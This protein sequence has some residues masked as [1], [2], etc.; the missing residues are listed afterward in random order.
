[1]DN[2]IIS[3]QTYKLPSLHDYGVNE[4]QS[5]EILE[6]WF[7]S[8]YHQVKIWSRIMALV[9][10]TP[11]KQCWEWVGALKNKYGHGSYRVGGKSISP[12]VL[13]HLVFGGALSLSQVVHHCCHNPYCVRPSHLIAIDRKENAKI[14]INSRM[15]SYRGRLSR[16]PINIPFEERLEKWKSEF[17]AFYVV[18]PISGCFIWKGKYIVT[19]KPPRPSY[20]IVTAENKREAVAARSAYIMFMLNGHSIPNNLQVL[21]K[22]PTGENMHCVN[23]GHLALGTA[24]ENTSDLRKSGKFIN[25]YA[26]PN[27]ILTKDDVHRI[28]DLLDE[29]KT[30]RQIAEIIGVSVGAIE[31]IREGDNHLDITLPRLNKWIKGHRRGSRAINAKLSNEQILQMRKYAHD[32]PSASYEEIAKLYQVH[33]VYVSQVCLGKKRPDSK[34]SYGIIRRKRRLSKEEISSIILMHLKQGISQRA[35][36]KIYGVNKDTINRIIVKT[37]RKLDA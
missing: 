18:D 28:C 29:D 17:S 35:I 23:P 1:M 12:Y 15:H 10:I 24:K 25:D 26:N 6:N 13:L 21:H 34:D 32:N 30:C 3:A 33:P 37:K 27:S 19:S 14:R 4:N 5:T 7:L 16:S 9:S 31:S 2:K 36:A 8:N 11:N 22:C 20:R